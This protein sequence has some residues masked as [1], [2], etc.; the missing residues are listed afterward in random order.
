MGREF[1]T[2]P[3]VSPSGLLL[4]LLVIS[5]STSSPVNNAVVSKVRSTVKL[6]STT[7]SGVNRL[8]FWIQDRKSNHGSQLSSLCLSIQRGGSNDV[9]ESDYEEDVELELS[10]TEEEE[11]EEEEEKQKILSKS[12]VS[13]AQKIKKKKIAQATSQSKA[14]VNT[15][16]LQKTNK[17]KKRKTS[18]SLFKKLHVPYIIRACMNPFTVIAMTRAYFASLFNIAFLEGEDPS[19][20]LRSALEAKAKKE[21][22]STG[23]PGGGKKRGKRM[24]KPGKAKTLADLPALNA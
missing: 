9:V 4:F 11:E 21:A 10:D 19:Q 3:K 7:H 17:K 14:K 2:M 5:S 23:G 1:S 24:M 8:P 22:L 20:G 16:L 6:S 15:A 12:T 13:A 18:V